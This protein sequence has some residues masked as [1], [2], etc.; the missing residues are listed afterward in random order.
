VRYHEFL[1]LIDGKTTGAARASPGLVTTFAD[2]YRF[3]EFAAG[4]RDV[5]SDAVEAL[6]RPARV[7]AAWGI[8]GRGTRRERPSPR[9]G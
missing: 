8:S 6:S 2:V 3:R 7:P 4:F 9:E 5:P 1:Q